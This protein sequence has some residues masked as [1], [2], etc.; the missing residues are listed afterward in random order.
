MSRFHELPIL[1][2]R[3][4]T[5]DAV[6]VALGVPPECADAFRFEPGQY[7]TLR[8]TIDGEEV[9]RPYS[10]CAGVDDRVLRVGIKKVPGGRFSTYANVVLRPG[11]TLSVMP[12]LGKFRWLAPEKGT[13]GRVHAGFAAGSGITPVLSIA[14]SVLSRAPTDRFTLFYGNRSQADIMFLEELSDL[15]DRY[16]ER[17]RVLYLFSRETTDVDVLQGR[18]DGAKVS[19]LA[20]AGTFSPAALD[21]AY[22][23]GP[24]DMID[25]VERGLTALGVDPGRIR[26]ERF[27]PSAPAPRAV[28][29]AVPRKGLAVEAVLDGVQRKFD[30][31]ADENVISAAARQNI[32]LPYSCAGGMCCTCRCRVVEGEVDMA[33]NYSLEPW[34]LEAGFVLACQSRPKTERVVLD[35]DAQ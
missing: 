18:L 22:V 14:K 9:R 35:F 28:L 23:C 13:V 24:G 34:E 7:L 19:A 26:A 10:I 27:T 1:D 32:E 3:R 20:E 5:A 17:F 2:V 31:L 16:L 25:S 11:M 12:P 4:E 29:Q 8:A 30:V 15:K 6:S 21:M 33:T